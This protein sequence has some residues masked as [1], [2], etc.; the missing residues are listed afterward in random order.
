MAADGL[1]HP[2]LPPEEFTSRIHRQAK[3]GLGTIVLVLALRWL[4]NRVRVRLPE[5]LLAIGVKGRTDGL[6]D[7][8]IIMSRVAPLVQSGT[9]GAGGAWTPRPSTRASVDL[10]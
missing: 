1:G 6:C 9:V 5:L 3:I 10:A 2:S 8:V 4:G 7:A